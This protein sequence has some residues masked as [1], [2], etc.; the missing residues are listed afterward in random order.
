MAGRIDLMA[1]AILII[2]HAMTTFY[3]GTRLLL[4]SCLP[5][6][7]CTLPGP[8][9]NS[10]QTLVAFLTSWKVKTLTCQRVSPLDNGQL[11]LLMYSV[12]VSFHFNCLPLCMY[13]YTHV[14]VLM[15]FSIDADKVT[16][17]I[18]SSDRTIASAL[19]R[20]GVMPCSPISPTVGI[21]TKA[22]DLYCVMH[23]R[24]P[25]LSIQAFVKSVSDLCGVCACF[26][27]SRLISDHT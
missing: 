11:M 9:K 7:M 15:Y 18:L 1:D 12:S 5:W 19:I 4:C 3:I 17:K 20:Q 25:H 24:S 10:R 16:V 6:P 27:C 26:F 23:L 13:I 21:T 22:L 14:M 8:W 2:V